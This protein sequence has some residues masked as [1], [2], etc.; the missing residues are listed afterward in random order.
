MNFTDTSDQEILEIAEP[1][2][3]NIIEGSNDLNYEKFSRD[4]S[5]EMSNAVPEEE[6]LRQ[7]KEAHPVTGLVEQRRV[8]IHCIRRNTGV[9]VLWVGYNEK[10][11]GEVLVNLTLDEKDG[12]IKVFGASVG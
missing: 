5:E 4:F 12:A 2:I 7:M 1:I 9:T 8:F 6:L 3:F 11:E 10:I